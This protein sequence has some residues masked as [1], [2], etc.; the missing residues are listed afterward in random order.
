M[1]PILRLA[2]ILVLLL[3]GI[4]VGAARGTVQIGGQV[5]LCTGQGTV[6]RHVPDAP[7]QGRMHICPDMAL[8][9]LNATPPAAPVIL[10]PDMSRRAALT[11]P[12]ETGRSAV[13]PAASARDPPAAIFAL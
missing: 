9:L 10:T 13:S 11:I 5:V 1:Q 4:G 12:S 2:L 3:T 6:V 7:G 8:A